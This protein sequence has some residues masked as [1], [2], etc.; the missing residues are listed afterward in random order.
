MSKV[1]IVP[2]LR[3]INRFWFCYAHQ[4]QHSTIAWT[5]TSA[6]R[7]QEKKKTSD[8]HRLEATDTRKP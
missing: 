5:S 1:L 2:N 8:S 7:R 4:M 6:G 3:L